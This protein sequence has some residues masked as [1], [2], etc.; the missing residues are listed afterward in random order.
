M[1]GY[2]LDISRSGPL[3]RRRRMATSGAQVPSL[4]VVRRWPPKLL[5]SLSLVSRLPR[6][7]QN[8]HRLPDYINSDREP[9]DQIRIPTPRHKHQHRREH[10]ADSRGR[11]CALLGFVKVDDSRILPTNRNLG[12]GDGPPRARSA[13]QG[14]NHSD[15]IGPVALRGAIGPQRR[16]PPRN[17]M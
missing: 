5:V 9:D 13:Q 11:L 2:A 15:S 8:L 14:P 1:R 17:L 6:T 10:D 4:N 12:A 7:L 16:A 3:A